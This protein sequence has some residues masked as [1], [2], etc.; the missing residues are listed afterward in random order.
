MAKDNSKKSKTVAVLTVND[1]P[2]MHPSTR[3][4]LARWLNR[5]AD[6]LLKDHKQYS[7]KYRARYLKN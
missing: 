5:Q 4:A 3:R 7:D 1:A 6:S 2:A